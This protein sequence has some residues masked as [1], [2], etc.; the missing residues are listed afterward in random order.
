MASELQ[1]L[2]DTCNRKVFL[3]YPDSTDDPDVHPLRPSSATKSSHLREKSR[4]PNVQE[5]H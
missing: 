1:T 2:L 4:T 5:D 3:D